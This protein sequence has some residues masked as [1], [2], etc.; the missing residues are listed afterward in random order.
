VGN[1]VRSVAAPV[2]GSSPGIAAMAAFFSRLAAADRIDSAERLELPPDSDRLERQIADAVN[3]VLERLQRD[4][5]AIEELAD[6]GAVAAARNTQVL[7]SI[8]SSGT[9][10]ARNLAQADAAVAETARTAAAV[11]AT[12]MTAREHANELQ[13][14]STASFGQITE[15]LQALVGLRADAETAA[16]HVGALVS[17]S[18]RIAEVVDVIDEISAQTNLLA[19]NASIE[20]ARAGDA[21][22][23]FTVVAAE[24]RKL[25]ESTKHST[26]QIAATIKDVDRSVKAV[27]RAVLDSV[28]KTTEISAKAIRIRDDLHAMDAAIAS[29]NERTSEIAA[30]AREQSVT[31]GEISKAAATLAGEAE[32]TA[33][34]AVSTSKL[35][36]SALSSKI[37]RVLA[38]YDLG[39][40]FD[41]LSDWAS[42]AAGEVETVFACATADGS[43]R[44]RDLFD[45]DY[46][47]YRGAEI[48][49]LGSLFNVSRAGD[50]GF[51]PPK[52]R[53]GY[54]AAFD[55][56]FAEIV[57]RYAV[58]ERILFVCIVDINGFLLMHV[59]KYRQD[60]TGD[61]ARDL[62]GNRVKRI[63]DDPVGLQCGRAGVVNA[64]SVPERAK[65]TE[66]TRCGVDLRRSPGRRR[67]LLQAYA[68]DTGEVCCDLAVPV[69]VRDQHWGAVRIGFVPSG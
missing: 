52:Y 69:Y 62:V 11:S 5:G 3:V 68:R 21:G 13:A 4:L 53:T 27:E 57:D 54:D 22:R 24:V 35:G 41:R 23:G 51:D 25:A 28:L 16:Q 43:V 36:L 42:L 39:R 40:Y 15:A 33:R 63:F 20:A 44:E 66:F 59:K 60:I 48:R 56:K 6:K 32:H 50:G 30:T 38:N 55:R 7:K 8:A 29:S 2:S 18:Q 31:L 37:Y 34:L 47:E 64:E 58:F 14:R 49:K 12:A 9:E 26:R 17:A 46:V 61:P 19:L 45:T 10:T 1:V 65:R 67:V